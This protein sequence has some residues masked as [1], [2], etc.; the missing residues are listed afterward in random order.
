MGEKYMQ[1]FGGKPER[2]RPFSRL[3]HRWEENIAVDLTEIGWE[4]MD[5]ILLTQD[6]EK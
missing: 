4:G 1:G 6:L 2:K 5:W 3:R